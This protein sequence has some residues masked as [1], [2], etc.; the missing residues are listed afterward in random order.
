MLRFDY[1]VLV[2][3]MLVLLHYGLTVGPLA[4]AIVLFVAIGA[5]TSASHSNTRQLRAR[6]CGNV[7]FYTWPMFSG[8][9]IGGA[10]FGALTPQ[11]PGICSKR[12]PG[13]TVATNFFVGGLVCAALVIAGGIP[14]LLPS[15]YA[16]SERALPPVDQILQQ[17]RQVIADKGGTEEHPF[18]YQR[19]NPL[20]LLE[21]AGYFAMS[22]KMAVD[23]FFVINQ[24]FGFVIGAEI[25]LLTIVFSVAV[26]ATGIN[27]SH[28]KWTLFSMGVAFLTLFP[29]IFSRAMRRTIVAWLGSHGEERQAAAVAALM[30]SFR[31]AKALAWGRDTFSGLPFDRLKPLLVIF[32]AAI[33]FGL[34]VVPNILRFI[35]IRVGVMGAATRFGWNERE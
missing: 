19:N 15:L 12:E 21:G 1:I 8:F 23:R 7:I 2:P 20:Y 17:Q 10:I 27:V 13:C 26:D 3:V 16:T 33:L 4:V 34:V 18:V 22:T 32:I 31:P 6:T 28:V 25:I 11:V 30:G 35:D 9:L 24:V 29:L 14:F 5:A